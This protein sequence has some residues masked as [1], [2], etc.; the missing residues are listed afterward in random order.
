MVGSI[1]ERGLLERVFRNL[2]ARGRGRGRDGSSPPAV[3]VRESVDTVFADL[4]GDSEAAVVV[5]EYGRPTGVLT[6]ADLLEYLANH[7]ER[8]TGR[9]RSGHV[10]GAARDMAQ[11]VTT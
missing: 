3:E 9:A 6:R 11:S 2:G 4:S 8:L 5:A 7:Q 1:R 10:R